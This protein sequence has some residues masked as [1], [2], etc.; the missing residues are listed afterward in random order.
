VIS[1]DCTVKR[2]LSS[3]NTSAFT[4][5]V[6]VVGASNAS[7]LCATLAS[8]GISVTNLAVPGWVASEKNIGELISKL[9]SMEIPPG[10]GILF[11]LL[12]NTTYRYEQLMAH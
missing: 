7:N 4:H 11:D 5:H 12:G 1:P 8:N 2:A 3:K 6:I 10:V 9:K